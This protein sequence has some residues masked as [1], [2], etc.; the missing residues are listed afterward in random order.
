MPVVSVAELKDQLNLDRDDYTFD[1]LL[2]RKLDAAEAYVA[3]FIGAALPVTEYLDPNADPGVEPEVVRVLPAVVTQA[4]LMLA[5]FWFETRE[6]AQV[7]GN[8]Y[9]VPFGVHDL[10][11]PLRQWVV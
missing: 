10:L 5:A 6:A 9:T 4:V 3:S 8:P 7:G 2:A 11:Q 1:S